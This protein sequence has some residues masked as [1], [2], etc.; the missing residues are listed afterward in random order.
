MRFLK[1]ARQVAVSAAAV[2][3]AATSLLAVT[4]PSAS[5]STI[6]NQWVQLCAQGDYPVV[7]QFPYRGMES[8]IVSP[9]QCNWWNWPSIGTWEP[10]NV[11]DVRSHKTVGTAWY[12]GDVSGLGIGAE[13]WEGSSQWIQTW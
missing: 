2:C 11:I 9:G 7:L 3:V 13:G 5:A 12:K 10:V 4:A 6:Q 8:T 1:N